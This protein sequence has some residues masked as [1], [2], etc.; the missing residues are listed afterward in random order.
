MR[1]NMLKFI[2]FL[3]TCCFAINPPTTWTAGG[4]RDSLYDSA[5]IAGGTVKAT[6][7]K[8]KFI[9]GIPDSANDAKLFAGHSWPISTDSA[10]A[11]KF[12]DTALK[13]DNRYLGLHGTADSTK[14]KVVASKTADTV[15]HLPD[16]ITS[17]LGIKAPVFS[18]YLHGAS[19]TSLKTDNRYQAALTN[20][21][22][23]TGTIGNYPL[24]TGSHA[25][26][27]GILT[28]DGNNYLTYT[29]PNSVFNLIATGTSGNHFA[30]MYFNN[31]DLSKY[32]GVTQYN[33]D[34][35]WTRWG[36]AQ[37]NTGEL[38]AANEPLFFG[39]TGNNPIH[40]GLNNA[41]QMRITN[42][43]VD[44][45]GVLTASGDF[46]SDLTSGGLVK[47]NAST[48]KLINYTL[49]PSDISS[50]LVNNDSG[51]VTSGYIPYQT[52]TPGKFAAS[53]LSNSSGF[54]TQD[55][56]SGKGVS[57]DSLN[58]HGTVIQKNGNVGIGK[59][60]PSAQLHIYSST[61]STISV[62]GPTITQQTL[63]FLDAGVAKTLLYRPSNSDAFS[64]A[65]GGTNRLTILDNNGNIGIGT[66]SPDSTLTV[67]GGI[68]LLNTYINGQL[69]IGTSTPFSTLSL[70]N[71]NSGI[72]FEAGAPTDSRRWWLNSDYSTGGDFAIAS[73]GTKGNAEPTLVRL[74]ISPLGKV[75]IGNSDPAY[76]LEVG[77]NGTSS[78]VN[79]NINLGAGSTPL[80]FGNG[81]Y[82][83]SMAQDMPLFSDGDISFTSNSYS[84]VI[85]HNADMTVP[86]NLNMSDATSATGYI[87][88]TVGANVSS[89]AT[90]TPSG[91]I[92]TVTGSTNIST[93]NVPYTGFTGIIYIIV[94]ASATWSTLTSGNIANA[95]NNSGGFY[96]G[97]CVPF[98]YDGSKWH[99]VS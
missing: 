83:I 80:T 62:D 79:F 97:Y 88:Q 18:G 3:S 60:N 50:G 2:L 93:I 30:E 69:G 1:R 14:C 55:A 61:G 16:T 10:R 43:E 44:V 23:G 68:H 34:V 82:A 52:T 56:G 13:Y 75:G 51:V 63:Q 47:S 4:F 24:W 57:F 76:G 5:L 39:C 12:S 78:D 26:G 91:P 87:Q 46:Y 38:L 9:L 37:A 15:L 48:G 27:N 41:E 94:G 21:V 20:P 81:G 95:L 19:D 65:V 22:T 8:G 33:A 85:V 71:T 29:N 32:F 11:S 99:I 28:Q 49:V 92:F 40:F 89:A 74:Y 98:L 31:A 66:T 73:E 84:P 42:G 77:T 86:G 35:L 36:Y 72:G 7:G 25:L 59:T 58:V 64:I 70:R 6:V 45:Y 90:I 54:I 17:R 53:S 67:N 96:Q